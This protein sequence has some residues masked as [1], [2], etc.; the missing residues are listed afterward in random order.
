[1]DKVKCPFCGK[2]QIGNP[3]KNWKYGAVVNVSRYKCSC[4]KLFNFYKSS[5]KTWTIPKSVQM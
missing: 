5:T 4:G 3:I 2:N 1:M